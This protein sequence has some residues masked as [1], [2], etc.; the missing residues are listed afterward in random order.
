MT[1]DGDALFRAI[2][3]QPWEDTPRLMNADWLQ[4]HGDAERA[5]FIRLMV[6]LARSNDET[7]QGELRTRAEQLHKEAYGRWTRG[8]PT[9]DGVR[10]GRE[11]H[12][13][14]YNEAYFEGADVFVR[15][16]SVVFA[17]TPIDMVCVRWLR[18]ETL[19]PILESGYLGRLKS[20]K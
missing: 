8:S 18:D 12:R 5:E 2:C 10:I 20:L 14:C 6:E 1:S 17:R 3:E 7:R 19:A 15:S 9:G 11:L 4:E 16:A 13:G